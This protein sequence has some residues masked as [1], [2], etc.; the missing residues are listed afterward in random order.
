MSLTP[1]RLRRVLQMVWLEMGGPHRE[2]C[3]NRT[4]HTSL[5]R[6]PKF[7]LGSTVNQ[8]FGRTQSIVTPPKF[9]IAPE[10]GWL[11]DYVLF[12]KAYF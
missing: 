10:N 8:C 2:A 11:E 6:N 3:L 5:L 4:V 7:A 12:G 1:A 9:N